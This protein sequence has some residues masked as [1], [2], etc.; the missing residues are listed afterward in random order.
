M[1]VLPV[2][3]DPANPEQPTAPDAGAGASV[4]ETPVVP[5][6]AASSAR[7][8]A[9]C[10]EARLSGCDYL[11]I[12]AQ[13]TSPAL[14]VQLTLDDCSEYG[15]GSGLTVDLPLT[16]QLASGSVS[17]SKDCDLLDFDPKSV[18]LNSTTGQMSWDQ[19]GR[20][21]SSLSIDVTLVLS[22]AAGSNVPARI[23]LQSSAPIAAVPECED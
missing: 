14:C 18:P 4:G 10:H 8:F 17:D 12:T 9:A 20:V 11:H 6:E 23:E 1:D 22:V 21:I 19:R 2:L 5:A 13:S 15:R 16:W 7:V 3:P